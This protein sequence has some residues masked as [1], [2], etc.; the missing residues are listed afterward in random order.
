MNGSPSR[1]F[2]MERGLRQGEPLS[3]FLFLIATKG[4][5]VMKKKN[6]K[7]HYKGIDIGFAIMRLSHLQYANDMIFLAP[8]ANKI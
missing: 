8:R 2:R 6:E 3:P 5:H 1:E 7:N 4:L